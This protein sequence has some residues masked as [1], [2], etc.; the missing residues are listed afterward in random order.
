MI[1]TDTR[2][3]P[4]RRGA[5]GIAISY[6]GFRPIKDYRGSRDLFNR[7]FVME[8]SNIPDSLATTAVLIMGEGTES[9]PIAILEDIP[10]LT[11]IQKVF[12]PKSSDDS[13]EIHEK[14]DMFY[15]FLSSVNWKKGESDKNQ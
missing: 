13:F 9:Q 7:E 8:T 4:I 11:F 15:P 5:V 1:I 14:E 12:K 6:F 3:V 10:N 2:L